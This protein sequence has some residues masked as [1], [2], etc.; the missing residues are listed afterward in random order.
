M[1]KDIQ[2]FTKIRSRYAA[3]PRQQK[4]IA[5]YVM[6]HFDEV[7]FS[8]ITELAGKLQVSEA[9]I[10]RFARQIGYSG[11]PELKKDLARYYRLYLNPAERLKR[12]M[13]KIH[14]KNS[15]EI[16]YESITR[17]EIQYLE[18][19]MHTISDRVYREAVR[20]ICRAKLR[21][22]YGTGPN[23]ALAEYLTYRLNRFHLRT[24]AIT[25]SGRDLFEELHSVASGDF[26]V[27]YSFYKPSLDFKRL[28]EILKERRIPMLL[29]TDS[30]VPP[31]TGSAP[32]VL[33]A[34]R[35]PFGLFHSPLVPMAITNALIIGIA[36]RLGDKAITALKEINEM[37][38]RHH[39]PDL[40]SAPELPGYEA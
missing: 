35:G 22:I 34:R 24:Q 5:D 8:S 29:I 6:D 27:V 32:L 37:R 21:Y 10:V 25:A 7:M 1:E 17:K 2:G 9:T 40:A 14:Q 20:A 39:Y 3:L 11:F 31:M 23:R 36:D 16:C 12:Y 15:D 38:R 13:G 19:S 4:K 26:A 18:D 28:T 33:Y 30:L